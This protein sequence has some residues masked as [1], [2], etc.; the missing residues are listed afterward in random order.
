M[1]DKPGIA[2]ALDE[3]GGGQTG[4]E[5]EGCGQLSVSVPYVLVV[6]DASFASSGLSSPLAMGELAPA[7]VN[8]GLG[9]VGGGYRLLSWGRHDDNKVDSLHKLNCLSEKSRQKIGELTLSKT[10]PLRRP[11]VNPCSDHHD[12]HGEN[13]EA[14]GRMAICD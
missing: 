5:G 1:A 10:N 9:L 6:G 13:M 14:V 4:A 7:V 3:F 2:D 8:I 11:V 12:L